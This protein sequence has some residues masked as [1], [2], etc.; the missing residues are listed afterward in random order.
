M[1]TDV[2]TRGTGTVLLVGKLGT[3]KTYILNKI[4]GT[5]FASKMC[6]ESCTRTIQQGFTCHYGIR[7]IDTPGFYSSHDT[8]SHT[9]AQRIA[10]E[11]HALSGVY[12][13]VKFGRSDEMAETLNKIMDFVGDEVRIII[14][15]CDF[16][17]LE[18]SEV[19][20]KS[21]TLRLSALVDVDLQHIIAV[22]KHTPAMEI[23]QFIAETLH[24][25]LTHE[26]TE[27]QLA[28]VH[29]QCVGARKFKKAI[30]AIKEKIQAASA[31]CHEL[32][33]SKYVAERDRAI[34]ETWQLTKSMVDAEKCCILRDAR[35]LTVEQH[36]LLDQE[37]QCSVS[38]PFKAFQ[39]E[40]IVPHERKDK[41][42][43]AAPHSRI[44]KLQAQFVPVCS[45]PCKWN[46]EY[47]VGDSLHSTTAKHVVEKIHEENAALDSNTHREKRR[48]NGRSAPEPRHKNKARKY[49]DRHAPTPAEPIVGTVANL[50]NT[51]RHRKPNCETKITSHSNDDDCQQSP[52]Q[53]VAR[54]RKSCLGS[55][56]LAIKRCFCLGIDS[57]HNDGSD[58]ASA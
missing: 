35:E 42:A 30:Q 55:C 27:L 44:P 29:D 2:A 41:N 36:Y 51:V 58:D 3:G 16:L 14:S 54:R 43:R 18:S 48:R 23:E 46:V 31:A 1:A 47:R 8:A 50:S 4:C 12:V 37:I 45:E 28:S 52:K 24:D 26:L 17:A 40:T 57:I 9:E 7:V 33:L 39:V 49:V 10:M 19:D 38:V 21:I 15:H 20:L 5:A 34:F 32:S 6:A 22:G 53:L 11:Q 25:P 13:V 56:L